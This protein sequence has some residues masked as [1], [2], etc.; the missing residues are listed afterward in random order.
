MPKAP[1]LSKTQQQEL[2]R[3]VRAGADLPTL[4]AHA[5]ARGWTVSRATLGALLKAERDRMAE[6]P[7]P[8]APPAPGELADQ[9]AE[10]RRTVV[11]LQARLDGMLSLP[12]VKLSE[13]AN[14]AVDVARQL[15][16]SPDVDARAKAAIMA[17][18]PDLIDSAVRAQE[19]EQGAGDEDLGE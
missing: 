7:A 2:R 14:A 13:A 10:L 5:K 17:Q 15:L 19:L 8:A 12:K 6:A 4:Q 11:A 1:A 18:L 9:V 16:A 3:K